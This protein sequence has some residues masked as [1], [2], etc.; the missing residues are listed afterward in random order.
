MKNIFILSI[1]SIIFIGCGKQQTNIPNWYL[2]SPN[3]TTEVIYGVGEGYSINEAKN[4]ALSE[5]S[6]RLIV[7]VGSSINTKTT[8][9]SSG[10]YTKDTTKDV[11]VEAQKIKFHNAVVEKTTNIDNIIYIIMKVDRVA[12]F[13]EKKKEFLAD[14]K[15][16]DIKYKRLKSKS[17]L[18]QI[19]A[20]RDMQPS[21]LKI[22]NKATVLYATNNS[23]NYTKYTSKYDDY[24]AQT[25]KLK[26]N[27]TI[28]VSSN[29]KNNFFAD[30]ISEEL[31]N[32][33]YKI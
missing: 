4:S 10:T 5:M 7:S 18:E 28:A 31:N 23:F 16:I 1:I 19:F 15:Q 13:T 32:N 17:I 22:K 6:S 12:L 25:D 30:I 14:N 29:N 26:S 20:L 3:N 2:N 11:I 33:N 21:I 9:S 24:L 8:S 27:I